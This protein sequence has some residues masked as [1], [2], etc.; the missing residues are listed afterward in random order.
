MCVCVCVYIH[1]YNC[2]KKEECP[3]DGKCRANDIVYKCIAS[4]T[5]FPNKVYLETAKGEFKIRFYNHNTS[6][7]NEWKSSDTTPA[8]YTWDLTSKQCDTYIEMTHF[9]TCDTIFEHYKYVKIIPPR[10]IGNPLIP[11]QVT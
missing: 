9:K 10:E 1:I 11:R 6:F 3:L 4:A 7:K 5:G 2:R 8:K